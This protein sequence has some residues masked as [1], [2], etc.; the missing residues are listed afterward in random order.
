MVE[1]PPAPARFIVS[2]EEVDEEEICS[3]PVALPETVGPKTT[4][5]LSCWPG[6]KIVPEAR[7]V[8]DHSALEI[9]TEL[10]VKEA[11]PVFLI[12]PGKA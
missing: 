6:A 12:V 7:P 2:T 10:M 1:L 8:V 5:K 9:F 11:L 4:A 3:V